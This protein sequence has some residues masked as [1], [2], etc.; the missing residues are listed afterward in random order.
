MKAFLI[1]PLFFSNFIVLSQ[2]NYNWSDYN[3]KGFK[4]DSVSSFDTY[5]D[6]LAEIDKIKNSTANIEIRF[7]EMPVKW[8]RSKLNWGKVNILKFNQN[9][10]TFE[11]IEFQSFISNEK[12]KYLF[13]QGYKKNGKSELVRRTILNTDAQ[14]FK[15]ILDSLV[16]Y[17]LFIHNDE[18]LFL[19][20]LV[21]KNQIK[22]ESNHCPY[23][24]IF[25]EL[26]VQSQF[27]N[28]NL[29]PRYRCFLKLDQSLFKLTN[30]VLNKI[31]SS[32]N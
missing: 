12:A 10:I 14:G 19:S 8:I 21:S 2:V 29:D 24:Q 3:Y 20:N 5:S 13:K 16:N 18:S 25:V 32:F 15:N 17:G 22:W 23:P 27:R 9:K 7:Y 1:L 31:I 6:S 26:K 30:F 28:F 11:K 4:I